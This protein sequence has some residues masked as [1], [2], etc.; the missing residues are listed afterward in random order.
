MAGA[1]AATTFSV[2]DVEMGRMIRIGI[3]ATAVFFGVAATIHLMLA[4]F[5]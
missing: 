5:I 1:A 2:G 3:V 4:P